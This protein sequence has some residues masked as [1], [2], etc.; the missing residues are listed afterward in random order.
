MKKGIEFMIA[1]KKSLPKKIFA[2]LLGG[3][4]AIG[5][6]P[7][8]AAP[9]WSLPESG[10]R[11]EGAAEQN[12]VAEK[13]GDILNSRNAEKFSAPDGWGYDTLD[14]DGLKVERLE[15]TAVPLGRVVLQLH[16]GGYVAPLG[17]IYRHLAV[18][19]GVLA[20]A[21]AVYMVDYRVAPHY[22][23][24][25]AL[26]DAAQ[27]Y[28]YLLD[29]GIKAEEIIVFGDSAGGNLALALALRLKEQKLPQP[30]ALVLISPWATLETKIPSR[31]NNFA[32]DQ[33]LGKT[34]PY[35]YGAVMES[36]YGGEIS[37]N[38]S[39]LSPIYADLSGLAPMLIQA[40]GYE[41]LL[42]DSLLLLNKAVV[43]GVDATLSV[44]PSM[45][46]DFASI[47]PDLDES[48]DS[49]HEIKY[50]INRQFEGGE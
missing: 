29:H 30:R 7:L 12:Y 4:I 10:L 39:R 49:F 47:A 16:G 6:S 13:M 27:T 19:Q 46:H 2:C 31:K 3:A 50:F 48:V 25:A 18:K 40:G 35:M 17:D 44:Y 11:L 36:V 45:S 38:D 43:D 26:D 23:Y 37:K 42:D 1:S 21:R 20:E 24:P 15:N 41:T 8:S 28:K 33:I 32:R 34:N 9:A 22:R 5:A 14:L